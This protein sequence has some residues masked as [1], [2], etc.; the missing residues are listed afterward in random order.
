MFYFHVLIMYLMQYAVNRLHYIQVAVETGLLTDVN[1][2][3]LMET[4]SPVVA[5]TL[6]TLAA[7]WYVN[8]TSGLSEYETFSFGH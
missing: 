1:S 8:I 7:W 5:T 2:L 3:K 4:S 6:P